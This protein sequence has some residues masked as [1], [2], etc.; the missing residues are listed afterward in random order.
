MSTYKIMQD[1]I[2]DEI[3]RTDLTSQIKGA[4]VSAIED[5]KGDR[6]ARINDTS[7]TLL[8]VANQ[9]FYDL[10][11]ALL[12][13]TGAALPSGTTLI[14]VDQIVVNFNNW[15]QPL[16]PVSVGWLDVY[17]IPTYVGQPYYYALLG[18]RIRLGPTPDGVYTCTIRGHIEWPALTA[19]SDT[20]NWMTRGEKLVRGTAKAILGRDVLTDPDM[21]QAGMGAATE[22]R[23][24]LDRQTSARSTQRLAA[25]G[26]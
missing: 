3:Q 12:D 26:Y 20:N 10:S 14:E 9:Q 21:V 1:R 23:A 13:D 25:W 22:A 19:D 18:E 5:L 6:F 24:A 8:T 4:I 7:F 11:T 16:R 17:Q 15:F 2:A